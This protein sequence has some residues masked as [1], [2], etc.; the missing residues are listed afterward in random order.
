MRDMKRKASAPKKSRTEKKVAGDAP[1][2]LAGPRAIPSMGA[3]RKLKLDPAQTVIWMLGHFPEHAECEERAK[4][5]AQVFKVVPAPVW[6]FGGDFA[7]YDAG[8]EKLVRDR[9]V[10]AG[11]PAGEVMLGSEAT[12]LRSFDTIQEMSHVV[13]TAKKRRKKTLICISNSLQLMQVHAFLRREKLQ[14][15][16]V[17]TPM[18]DFR[19]WYVAARL[20]LAPLAYLGFGKDFVPLRVV[21]H[22]RNEWKNWRF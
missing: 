7:R 1:A 22:A 10:E 19:W 5:T 4:K 14:V 8:F 15:L 21:R 20:G 11:V 13:V 6:I 3:L 12:D 17:P 16:Y 2:R 18:R 9:V